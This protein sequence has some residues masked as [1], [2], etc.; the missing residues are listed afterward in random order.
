VS[1][2]VFRCTVLWLSKCDSVNAGSRR[3]LNRSCSQAR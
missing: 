3:M 2:M 1:S